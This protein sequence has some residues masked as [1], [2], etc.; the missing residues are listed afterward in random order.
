MITDPKSHSLLD[1]AQG[2]A[3]GTTMAAASLTLLAQSG[4]IT[5]Q[6]AGYAMLVAGLTGASFP[7]VYFLINLPFYWFGYRRFGRAF[8][9]KSF[10]AVTTVS[11]LMHFMPGWLTFG[12][13]SQPAVAV[14]FGVM[15]GLAML[16]LYRH[17]AALGG[18]GVLALWAQDRTGIRAGHVQIGFDILL[19]STFILLGQT[20]ALLWSAL[21]AMVLNLVIAVNHR[22]DRYIAA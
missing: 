18:L 21:G 4:M 20:T 5:G 1:D 17:G 16:A 7:V 12:V 3:I 9:I 8:L 19:F 13:Q 6:T 2:L 15:A 11:V 14:I 10:I 22:R